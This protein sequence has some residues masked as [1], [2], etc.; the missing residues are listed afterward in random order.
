VNLADKNINIS[1]RYNGSLLFNDTKLL[2][3]NTATDKKEFIPIDKFNILNK[4]NK[5]RSFYKGLKGEF[6]VI[7]HL[8]IPKYKYNVLLSNDMSFSCGSNHRAMV[9]RTNDKSEKVPSE[10]LT[11]EFIYENQKN[12]YI[13]W[14][15]VYKDEG[16]IDISYVAIKS[17]IRTENT[18]DKAMA[19][20]IAFNPSSPSVL[21]M[22]DNGVVIRGD[23][24]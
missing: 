20:G 8:N 18:D 3:V 24:E 9:Y 21:L 22:L 17:V 2:V 14:K 10:L 11:I 23:K 5:Y 13:P 19:Y 4:D 16:A 12:V 1:D 6:K 7:T 15:N